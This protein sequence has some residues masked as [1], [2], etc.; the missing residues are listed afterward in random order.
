M[1]KYLMILVAV[2]GFTLSVNAESLCGGG[3]RFVF[4]GA[5]AGNFV[6]YNSSG[7]IG[8]G[9]W[10][11]S[12]QGIKIMWNGDANHSQE[13]IQSRDGASFTMAGTTYTVCD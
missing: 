6:C 1:K 2:I 13:F 5:Y 7:E 9:T 12:R 8:K 10:G 11:Q 3:L 4:S